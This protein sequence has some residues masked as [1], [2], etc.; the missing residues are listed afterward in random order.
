MAHRLHNKGYRFTLDLYGSGEYES[1]TRQLVTKLGLEDVV[2]IMGAKPNEELL[3]DMRKHSIFLFTS[4]RNEGWGAVANESMANGCALVASN[5][6]GSAPYLIEDGKTGML[7]RSPS[8]SSSFENPDLFALNS[9]CEKV[10]YLLCNPCIMQEI[11]KCS[12]SLMQEVWNPKVAA[13]RLLILIDY[14]YKGQKEKNRIY[15]TGPCSK[16]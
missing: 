14:L 2:R 6:I 12:L 11:R 15:S 13:E 1:K 3:A 8:T 10:E 9:L 5:G 4:D 7:F 16:A